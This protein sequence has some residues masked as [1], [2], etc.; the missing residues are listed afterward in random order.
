MR[1]KAPDLSMALE[2]R[3]G[4]HHA[5]M[6]RLFLYHISHLDAMIAALDAQIEAMME[7]FRAARDLLRTIPGI[8]ALAAAAVISEIG[9]DVCEYFPDA[10]P[11]SA[12][13]SPITRSGGR[14][15]DWRRPL[16]V[17]RTWV[18]NALAA[19]G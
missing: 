11:P 5:L 1:S 18:D 6:C 15:A 19:V 9:A 7:P 12:G 3:F 2:G 10:A 13:M 16:A 14:P 17:L 8:T 4:D